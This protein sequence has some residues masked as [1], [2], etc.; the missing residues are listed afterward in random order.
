M[1]IDDLLTELVMRLFLD[2]EEEEQVRSALEKAYTR[3]R[4]DE[5]S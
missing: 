3:G 1:M 4:L 2:M 5:V